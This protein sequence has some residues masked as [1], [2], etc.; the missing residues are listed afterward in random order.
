MSV[1]GAVD[2]STDAQSAIETAG[3]RGPHGGI[4]SMT[5][6]RIATMSLAAA[7]ISTA[8]LVAPQALAQSTTFTYQGLLDDA[9]APTSGPHDF[10][11]RLFDAATGGAQLGSTLCSDNVDVVGGVFT[12]QLDFGQQFATTA[13]RHLEIE[14]RRDTGLSCGDVTGFVALSPRQQLTAAPMASHA[15]A[16]FALDAADGSPAGAVFVD[17]AGNVGI[18]TTGTTAK[19]HVKGEGDTSPDSGTPIA[20]FTRGNG[21]NFLAI[22]ADIGGNYIVANDPTNNQKDL[23][24]QT[25]NNRSILLE[26][27]GAARVYVRNDFPALT[28]LD[29]GAPS[30][31]SGYVG[32][33][34]SAG[35]MAWVGY[36]TPGSPHFS[37][38]NARAGG[39][40]VLSAL[41][42]G[43]D[44]VLSPGAGGAVSVPVLEITGA[45][46]AERFPCSDERVESGTVMEIDPNDPGKLRVARGA[47]NRRVAGVVSGANDFA[48]GAILGN[49]PGHE[50]APPIALSGRVYVLCDA[51]SDPIEPGDLLTTSN[52]PGYAMKAATHTRAQGA[53]LG[54]AMTA[55]ESGR[56]TVLVL[57]SLQ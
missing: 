6:T 1:R 31:Q 47:Y 42:A 19:L 8:A 33:N 29:S 28:L 44:I 22:F 26:P 24:L 40:I 52:T 51:T 56:G 2:D 38:V 25:R 36:G 54:K 46:L 11:F 5:R 34:S 55:L 43:G 9:G 12:A 17:N 14:V 21:E 3:S 4:A 57:V 10:R 35:E 15:S 50:N 41:G 27:D 32:F 53:I 7:L 49:L 16:A 18:G 20:K 39:N 30:T 23:R 13:Q 48:A 37:V 45:D